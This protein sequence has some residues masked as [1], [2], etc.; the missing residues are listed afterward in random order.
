M[1]AIRSYYEKITKPAVWASFITGVTI[2]VTHMVLF[3]LNLFPDLVETVKGWNVKI[4]ILSPI[5]AGAFAM[6]VGL[7]IV[8]IVSMLTKTKDK[9]HIEEVFSCYS[10]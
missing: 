5:N 1:Y 6:I 2:T 10:K 8:P 9:E 4:A 7:I 3:S